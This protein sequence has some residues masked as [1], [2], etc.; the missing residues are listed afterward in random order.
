MPRSPKDADGCLT[1]RLAAAQWGA[2]WDGTG[3]EPTLDLRYAPDE[4]GLL[5]PAPRAVWAS[6][7][8]GSGNAADH[9]SHYAVDDPYGARRGAPVVSK[10]F[11]RD[12]RAEQL[13]FGAG[14]TS[15][16]HDV[17]RLADGRAVVAPALVHSD[18]E[19]WAAA[20]GSAIHFFPDTATVDELEAIIHD[21]RPGVLHFDRPAFTG[22]LATGRTF[23]RLLNVA[24]DNDTIVVIDEGPATYLGARVSAV[25][26]I[27]ATD[28]L[29][30]L[31]G[32]T[33]AYSLGGMRAGYAVASSDIA[34]R[35]RDVMTPLQI[36]EIALAVALRLLAA[37]DVFALLVSRIRRRKPEVQRLL[38]GAGFETL[39]G[40]SDLPWI[41]VVDDTGRSICRLRERG[42]RPLLPTTSA[43][44]PDAYREHGRGI[45]RL[46]I[47]LSDDRL[48]SLH[49]LLLG[50][51]GRRV[52]RL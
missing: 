44:F 42:I 22:E 4:D 20:Q 17:S 31:R 41:A 2:S 39:A 19:V 46:T 52:G 36:G 8:A 18:L 50:P 29:V 14:V 23:E 13:T 15:L 51:D 32:F 28:K 25:R 6:L 10:F 7:A 33:K 34:H 48:A 3:A 35:V 24:S 12:I 1:E 40:E 26:Y 9:A 47:P 27:D 5:D 38:N 45:F 49:T 30:V 11:N 37:G 16:L 21:V 43:A